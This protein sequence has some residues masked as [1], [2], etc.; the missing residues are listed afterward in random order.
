MDI[1]QVKIKP[2]TPED[3]PVLLEMIK[4]LATFENAL[5]EVCNTVDNLMN[6]CFRDPPYFKAWLAWVEN[7][8]VGMM[9]TYVRYSTWRGKVLY[10]DDIYVRPQWR[11]KGIGEAM[12]VVLAQEAQSQ[13]FKFISWQVLDWNV[14]AQSFFNKWQV[15]CDSSWINF[16]WKFPFRK[17]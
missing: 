15:E 2:A 3:M 6:D 17:K 8:P 12:M 4:E 14:K 5:D 13:N 11:G 7:I 10:L 1:V 9:I 16:L